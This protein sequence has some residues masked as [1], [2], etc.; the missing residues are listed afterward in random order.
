MARNYKSCDQLT[1]EMS[2]IKKQKHQR[3]SELQLWK[4]KQQQSKWYNQKKKGKR[5]SSSRSPASMSD[6]DGSLRSLSTAGPNSP[7]SP[8]T[9]GST[10]FSIASSPESR[11]KFSILLKKPEGDFYKCH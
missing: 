11:H 3:E 4:R 9:P 8:V 1:E 5:G 2:L 10:S 6:S 7:Q